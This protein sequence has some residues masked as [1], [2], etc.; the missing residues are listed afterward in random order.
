M[1]VAYFFSSLAFAFP[2]VMIN[3][4]KF[5]FNHSRYDQGRGKSVLEVHGECQKIWIWQYR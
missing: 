2:I 1:C 5:I 3:F 4:T